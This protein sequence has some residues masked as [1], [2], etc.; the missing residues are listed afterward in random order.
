MDDM[1]EGDVSY[2]DEVDDLQDISNWGDSAK[3][4]ALDATR[5]LK[6]GIDDI[7]EKVKDKVKDKI[8]DKIEDKLKDKLNDKN[9]AKNNQN[10]SSRSSNG[11]PQANFNQS[12]NG[13]PK[14]NQ[15]KPTG[16]PNTPSV[17]N[18][19]NKAGNAIK[20]GAEATG[21]AAKSSVETAGNIAKSGAETAG[22]TAK[23]GADTA[24]AAGKATA[25]AAQATSTAVSAT[26]A[27]TTAT[28]EAAT[29]VA[30]TT[31]TALGSII[32]ALAPVLGVI[33]G[34]ILAIALIIVIILIIISAVTALNQKQTNEPVTTECSEILDLFDRF[35]KY[36]LDYSQYGYNYD[37]VQY[38]RKYTAIKNAG[39]S[40]ELAGVY[41][42]IAKNNV[43]K[44]EALL[45]FPVDN[46]NSEEQ[47]YKTVYKNYLDYYSSPDFF[48]AGTAQPCYTSSISGNTVDWVRFKANFEKGDD[49]GKYQYHYYFTDDLFKVAIDSFTMS[50]NQDIIPSVT[51]IQNDLA[52]QQNIA[53]GSKE[54]EALADEAKETAYKQIYNRMCFQINNAGQRVQIELFS[55]DGTNTYGR[56]NY[57]KDL[58]IGQT[59]KNNNGTTSVAPMSVDGNDY[60]STFYNDML[61]CI[62]SMNAANSSAYSV[63]NLALSQVGNDYK[64]YCNEMNNGQATEWCA[65][66]AGWCLK[67]CGMNLNDLGYSASV[68][69]WKKNATGK[70]MYKA[71]N[72]G[73]T[74]KVGD[75]VIYDYDPSNGN[76][77]DHIEIVVEVSG[78]TVVTVGGNTGS[79]GFY[80]TRVNKFTFNYKDTS[81]SIVG[82]INI[83][84]ANTSGMCAASKEFQQKY[85]YLN[86]TDY[87]PVAY[88]LTDE[89]RTF[90]E[91]VVTGEYGGDSDGCLIVAQCIRD[92]LV[93]GRCN[94]AMKIKKS[95]AEGGLGYE[96]WKDTATQEAKDAVRK[97]FD[98]GM[99]A[100]KYKLR[101]MCT[102]DY[103]TENPDSFFH[104]V[105]L[106]FKYN[107]NTGVVCFF[108][109]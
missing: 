8:E 51:Q 84:Y 65:I 102:D 70:G 88:K 41:K 58:I 108:S 9:N 30:A 37:R 109:D 18:T 4:E 5:P 107:G 14:G 61:S 85:G 104:R 36:G 90:V 29:G 97:I 26:T 11:N 67:K 75:L 83:P 13:V 66:F 98:Q 31:T 82:F 91:K 81:S 47:N 57:V 80:N 28:A 52:K 86:Q 27:A 55:S 103:Y 12:K 42:L 24:A 96:G 35:Q 23:A 71:N 76:D 87:A 50:N 46:S 53:E 43:F 101:Y 94:D 20:S 15:T 62:Y 63:A 48:Q 49:N 10:N 56:Y 69:I 2:G 22:K 77:V 33:L 16:T 1:H 34:I 72:G 60:K 106:I 3:D 32:A 64:T 7:K 78:N 79:G 54:Y 74:P 105:P 21:N 73:Y 95:V 38:R 44:H 93:D 100:V 68:P 92:A 40:K 17:A 25:G 19:S 39:Y 59:K 45:R 6:D 99:Y 89:Q